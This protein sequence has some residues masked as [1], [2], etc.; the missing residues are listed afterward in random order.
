MR[1]WWLSASIAA[2]MLIMIGV[3]AYAGTA[4]N[5]SEQVRA[6]IVALEQRR[7]EAIGSGDARTLA[8][9]LDDEYIHVHGTGKVDTKGGFIAN[10]MQR[11]RRTERGELTV[12]YS[13][14]WR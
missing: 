7:C 3:A 11:P 13:A 14:I 1:Q 4:T 2:A 5:T 6:Q 12:R 8:L 10:V 9:I